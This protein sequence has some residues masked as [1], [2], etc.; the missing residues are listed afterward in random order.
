VDLF[1]R[2]DSR[3]LD[4]IDDF[5]SIEQEDNLHLDFKV[6]NKSDFFY[7]DDRKNLAKALSG[8]SNSS[9][10]LNYNRHCGHIEK[11]VYS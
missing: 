10:G 6:I 11:F 3:S 8:F 4:D 1:D 9:G 5:I 7:N 2:F